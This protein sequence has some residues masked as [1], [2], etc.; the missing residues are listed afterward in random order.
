MAEVGV[1]SGAQTKLTIKGAQASRPAAESDK[2]TPHANSVAA[3]KGKEPVQ[4]LTQMA[5]DKLLRA[6]V[7]GRLDLGEPLSENDLAR[8]LNLS[9]APIRE[10]LGELRLRGLVE[11]VPRSGSYVFSPTAEQIAE[12]SDYRALLETNALRISM[13]RDPK[14]LSAALRRIVASMKAAH[15]REDQTAINEL[16]Q[17]FH[18]TIIRLSNNRYLTESYEHI[19]LTVEALRYRVMST[20][21]YRSKVQEEHTRLADLIAKNQYARA[22]RILE[23]HIQRVQ[24]VQ[25]TAEWGSGRLKRKDYHFRDYSEILI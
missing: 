22:S 20:S 8:A 17:E 13:K 19:S 15:L 25:S 23:S 9:K 24:R 4:K 14:T 11:V 10:S 21:L 7:Q 6:I 3:L 5:Y 1:R 2:R 16:D 12:L 18:M